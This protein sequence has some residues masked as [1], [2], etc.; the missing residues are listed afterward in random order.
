MH[1]APCTLH[2][3]PCTLH[4]APCTLNHAPCTLH[5]PDW[6]AALI[7]APL[8]GKLRIWSYE[9]LQGR[10]GALDVSEI[11]AGSTSQPKDGETKVA[12]LR[13]SPV[14]HENMVRFGSLEQK[15]RRICTALP[16][17]QL[18]NGQPIRLRQHQR[19][20][21]REGICVCVCV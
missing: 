6:R 4:P 14:G 15:N 16:V 5:R 21:E 11:L 20:P 18:G 10:E 7:H 3:A 19:L 1:P 2:L 13:P 8:A 12:W 17:R 9:N